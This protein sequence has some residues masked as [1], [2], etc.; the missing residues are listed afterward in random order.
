M[1]RKKIKKPFRYAFRLV[2]EIGT[3]EHEIAQQTLRS[4]GLDPKS[5]TKDYEIFLGS[6]K[7]KTLYDDMIS[8]N[9]RAIRKQNQKRLAL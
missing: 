1:R 3:I 7:E 9:S 4:A 6:V 8:A 2:L 5:P